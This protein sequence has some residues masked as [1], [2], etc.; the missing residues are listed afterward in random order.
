MASCFEYKCEGPKLFVLLK[1]D[2][3]RCRSGEILTIKGFTGGIF[4]PENENLCNPKYNCKFGCVDQYSNS[5]SFFEY[6]EK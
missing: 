6:P 4:C 5:N 2:K 3:I 1:D